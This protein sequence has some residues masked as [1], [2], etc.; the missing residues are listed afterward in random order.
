MSRTLN[1]LVDSEHVQSYSDVM[2]TTMMLTYLLKSHKMQFREGRV[3]GDREGSI[4]MLCINVM[5]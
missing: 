2:Y 1:L 4:V 5:F 3:H